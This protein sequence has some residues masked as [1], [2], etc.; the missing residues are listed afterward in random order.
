MRRHLANSHGRDADAAPDYP[1]SRGAEAG[2]IFSDYSLFRYIYTMQFVLP[3]PGD[4]KGILR[5]SSGVAIP[6]QTAA[7][8]GL[9][10]ACRAGFPAPE[11]G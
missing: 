2:E 4:R 1:E 3:V 9:A 8:Q 7:A 6:R 5:P 11:I 10:G